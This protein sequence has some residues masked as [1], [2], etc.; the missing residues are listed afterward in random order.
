MLW[1]FAESWTFPDPFPSAFG[2][3]SVSAAVVFGAVP[4]F[5]RSLVLG[6]V[7]AVLATA[8]GTLAARALT[9]G[10]VPGARLVSA[11]LLAP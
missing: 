1:S 4:A 7:V 5:G 2:G 11:L 10:A 6:L 3:R 9:F 8:I